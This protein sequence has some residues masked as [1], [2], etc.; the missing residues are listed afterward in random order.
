VEEEDVS[1]IDD[2]Y[3]SALK[4][5]RH[6]DKNAQCLMVHIASPATCSMEKRA[7]KL[8]LAGLEG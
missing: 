7:M 5:N 3:R 8:V 1:L 6:R 2:E 4:R